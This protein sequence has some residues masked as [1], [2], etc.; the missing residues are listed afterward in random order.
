MCLRKKNSFQ[1]DTNL[2][3]QIFRNDISFKLETFFRVKT[4]NKFSQLAKKL[5][6]GD[7]YFRGWI[8]FLNFKEFI[9]AMDKFKR[10]KV[11]FNYEMVQKKVD[12]FLS[13]VRF[14]YSN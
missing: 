1:T 4:Q 7:I 12:L 14:I 10:T 8:I 2:V 9:F 3:K 11:A 6:F 5:I 13:K